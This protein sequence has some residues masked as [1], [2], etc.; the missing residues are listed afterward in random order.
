M[1][2]PSGPGV[3][4]ADWYQPQRV[5]D[6][7]RGTVCCHPV[8]R[9]DWRVLGGWWVR[10]R[11]R[12]WRRWGVEWLFWKHTHTHELTNTFTV[13]QIDVAVGRE[14]EPSPLTGCLNIIF[15]TE[16]AVL[17]SMLQKQAADL[18]SMKLQNLIITTLREQ[19]VP[20]IRTTIILL[21]LWFCQVFCALVW[22]VITIDLNSSQSTY[23]CI[24]L[25]FLTEST[26]TLSLNQKPWWNNSI[27]LFLHH[28]SSRP[29]TYADFAL[30][31]CCAILK[32]HFYGYL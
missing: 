15:A 27:D 30:L 12:Q 21:Y 20:G 2:W 25:L 32:Q 9:W 6:F 24:H 23:S 29:H 16:W 28:R 11:L 22:T 5:L 13:I 1:G 31:F 14:A 18:Q 4:Q 7:W 26:V 10:S 3:L 19:W 8:R 17:L